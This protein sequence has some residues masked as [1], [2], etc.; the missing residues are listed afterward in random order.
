[1][2]RPF[3]AGAPLDFGRTRSLLKVQDGCDS[4]CGFCVVP[5]VRGR[6]RSLPLAD[7]LEQAR[8][9]LDA[10]FHEIVLTGA[11][12]GRYGRDLGDAALLTRLVEDV[13]SLAPHHRVRISSIEPDK[14]DGALL[15]LL[16]SEPRLCR[17]LH[18]PLQ[19]GSEPILRAM[20]RNYTPAEY[21]A[22][23]E[24]AAARGPAGIGADVI[25]GFPGETEEDFE[26]TLR[27]VNAAPITYLHVFR[28][29]PRP[30]TAAAD[31]KDLP[32]P[33]VL[34][35]RSDRLRRLGEEKSRAFRASL[36]GSTLP[37]LPEPGAPQEPRRA[38]ADVY[39]P[40]VIDDP[41]QRPGIVDAQVTGLAPDNTL[42]GTIPIRQPR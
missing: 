18:L 33:V 30:G 28:Y 4:F 6:S 15:T 12:L 36:I 13:L 35:E 40:V 41:P 25:V 3:H 34:R 27:L 24:R 7:A 38:L 29:S 10:G 42:Q 2:R 32:P 11:D 37:V 21:L 39:V 26:R 5:Y 1:V 20:R 22:L 14:V 9:L 8:R 16:G 23:C 19:S 31:L 17:H